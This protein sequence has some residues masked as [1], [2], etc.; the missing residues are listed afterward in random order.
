MF[1]KRKYNR[2]RISGRRQQWILGGFHNILNPNTEG[3][4]GPDLTG[5]GVHSHVLKS[6]IYLLRVSLF[7]QFM[8][9]IYEGNFPKMWNT[10]LSF[11]QS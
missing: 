7:L 9:L 2:G 5:G 3:V 1:G 4:L 10:Q 6:W 8:I 11:T